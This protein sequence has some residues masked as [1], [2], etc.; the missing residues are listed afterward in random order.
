MIENVG[1]MYLFLFSLKRSTK[2]KKYSKSK[3]FMTSMKY[4]FFPFFSPSQQ[5]N[6][7]DL[8]GPHISSKIVTLREAKID[9][10][11]IGKK[12][13]IEDESI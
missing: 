12:E 9:K 1:L 10:R 8:I 7:I 3:L 11:V 4:S 5:T 6:K 13:E 2:K